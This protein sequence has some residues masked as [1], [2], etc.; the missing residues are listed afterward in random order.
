MNAE[1]SPL[2]LCSTARLAQSLRQ[3]HA[4]A[5][6][7]VGLTQWQPLQTFTL[8]QWLE[9]QV[10][11]LMLSGDIPAANA[12]SRVLDS[13]EERLLWE[14]TIEASLSGDVMKELFDSGGMASAAAEA[15]AL[16]QV[17]GIQIGNSSQA[18][19]EIRQ[20]LLWRKAFQKAC[21]QGDWLELVRYFDWQINQLAKGAVNLPAIIYIAGFDRIDPQQQRLFDALTARGVDVKL[22]Q[23][24][25]LKPAQ[26]VQ[27]ALDN[28]DGECRAAV[29]W[30]RDKLNSNPQARLAIVTPV[31]G[32]IRSRLA[33]ILDDT[34][35]PE[36]LH[37]SLYEQPRCYDFSLGLSLN[38]YPMIASAL[39]L[40]RFT[41]ARGRFNQPVCSALLRDVYWSNANELDARAALDARL[42]R[43]SGLTLTFDQ[44]LS[45]ANKALAEGLQ[46]PSLITHLMQIKT[47]RELWSKRKPPSKWVLLFGVLLEAVN[48]SKSRDLSSHEYQSKQAWNNTLN[49]F[50]AL[51]PFTGN[52]SASDAIQKLTQLCT[53]SIFQPQATGD[54][55]IQVMGMLETPS[56]LLDGVWVMAMNDHYWPPA[57]NP[58][59][60]LPVPLQRKYKTPNAGSDVQAEFANSIHQ[61]LLHS[62]SEVVFSWSRKDGD[63]ELRPSPL[64]QGLSHETKALPT[65]K[66]LAETLAVSA[67]VQ[68]LDD[69]LAPPVGATEKLRG[70]NSLFK[71]QAICPAWAFY[72]YRLGATALEEPIDGLDSMSRGSLVHAVLQ[73]FWQSCSSLS[74][75][76]AMHKDALEA[77]IHAAVEGGVKQF[78]SQLAEAIPQAILTLEKHRLQALLAEWLGVE[79]ERADFTVDVC[80]KNIPL[81]I[82]GLAVK[83]VIDRVDRLT[84]GGLVI[85]D[86]KT[87][88]APK[89]SSWADERISEPQLPIYAS[90]AL[91]DEKIVAVCFAVV[92]A[93]DC[94]F[95]G[96]AAEA[97]VLPKIKAFEA[98]AANSKFKRFADWDAL[99]SHWKESL[100]K[101]AD[102]IKSGEAGVVFT[103]E[104]DLLYCEVK[105]LL[106]LPERSLQFEQA[107]AKTL[108]ALDIVVKA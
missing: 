77:S 89:S 81:E 13:M 70:G 49:A 6:I 11:S 44:L 94:N 73:F 12:P 96:V 4:N 47:L 90:L 85:I 20:F 9:E 14:R 26:A 104:N 16:M 71:A 79:R 99:I 5:Q 92:R 51:D 42:R 55:R 108:D 45:Q 59:P 69:H 93:D 105:P 27:L 21:S 53:N 32:N 8:N 1:I 34:F 78:C 19:E 57:A 56:M 62:A 31:L 67:V 100:E 2:I 63:R 84:D 102:E 58:N 60:L 25:Q 36:T 50:A 72:Q 28:I 23:S 80:E 65:L 52:I 48:W 88:N 17:W 91:Q 54:I 83:V 40:L 18:T 3:A 75:L 35:H 38:D 39:A 61:R 97:D 46:I 64:L 101:I 107:E 22:W 106:R 74:A 76:K 24:T 95:S 66:T 41:G 15:N 98:L 30:V 7:A 87:G 29:A 43:K 86:Y 68:N 33:N 37:P 10:G 103:D 82:K